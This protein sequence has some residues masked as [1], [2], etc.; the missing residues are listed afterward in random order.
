ML[1]VGLKGGNADRVMEEIAVRQMEEAETALDAAISRVEPAMVLTASVLV[2]MI[3]LS[4]MLPLL[5][6]LSTLG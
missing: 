1:A 3:L 5:N 4:V 6:I 2:G